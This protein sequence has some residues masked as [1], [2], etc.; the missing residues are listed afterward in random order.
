MTALYLGSFEEPRS[1]L[2]LFLLTPSARTQAI[3]GDAAIAAI[4]L[5][6]DLCGVPM[7]L[8]RVAQ[9]VTCGSNS[10]PGKSQRRQK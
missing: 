7:F 6:T 1:D 5:R 4:F 9:T 10:K 2:F 3:V 8:V